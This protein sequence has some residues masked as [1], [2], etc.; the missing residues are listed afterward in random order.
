MLIDLQGKKTLGRPGWADAGRLAGF[1]S[2][3][4]AVMLLGMAACRAL[5][6]R[7]LN[8]VLLKNAT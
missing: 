4:F 2:P 7:T 3:G 8:G 5:A 1:E 6:E